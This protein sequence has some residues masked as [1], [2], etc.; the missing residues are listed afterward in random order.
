VRRGLRLLPPDAASEPLLDVGPAAPEEWAVMGLV[1]WLA[2]WAAVWLRRRAAVLIPLAALVVGLA[3]PGGL[4]WRRRAQAVG[5]VLA[6]ATAVRGAP[7]G[8]AAVF[9]SL[10]AGSAVVLGRRH[11]AWVEVLRDDGVHGWLLDGEVAAL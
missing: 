7:Y 5:V 2:F 1:A 10:P 11:G 4:E 9:G 8:G 3:V 6:P